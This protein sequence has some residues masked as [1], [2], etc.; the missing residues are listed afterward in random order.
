MDE[1]IIEINQNG[2]VPETGLS[3]KSVEVEIPEVDEKKELIPSLDILPEKAK[4]IYEE[5]NEKARTIISSINN[6]LGITDSSPKAL[7]SY[8]QVTKGESVP[9]DIDL[10]DS[11]IIQ[12]RHIDAD[13]QKIADGTLPES[14]KSTVLRQEKNPI[15]KISL[16]LNLNSPQNR[17]SHLE[18]AKTEYERKQSEIRKKLAETI[19]PSQKEHLN[20]QNELDKQTLHTI[21]QN[22]EIEDEVDVEN[23]LSF[24]RRLENSR[25]QRDRVQ[26]IRQ[27]LIEQFKHGEIEN[28]PTLFWVW[29]SL[30][31]QTRINSGEPENYTQV[32]ERLLNRIQ[33]RIG[34][35]FKE[36]V[37]N[38]DSQDTDHTSIYLNS[39]IIPLINELQDRLLA[40]PNTEN[41][42]KHLHFLVQG[43]ED[44]NS[45]IGQTDELFFHN[46]A[47]DE[48]FYS[49]MKNGIL[50]HREGIKKG[51]QIE[52]VTGSGAVNYTLNSDG[53]NYAGTHFSWDEIPEKMSDIRSTKDWTTE[54][55]QVLFEQNGAYHSGEWAVVFPSREIRSRYQYSSDYDGIHVFDPEY[56]D[57]VSV[58][59][60]K[61]KRFNPEGRGCHIE[62]GQHHFLIALTEK[63]LN[64]FLPYFQNNF[65]NL[66]GRDSVNDIDEWLERY[67]IRVND[68]RNQEE[69]S[70]IREAMFSRYDVEKND[71]VEIASGNVGTSTAHEFITKKFIHSV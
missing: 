13:F 12:S 39:E 27:H 48:V 26:G 10:I 64:Q 56:S 61:T 53:I 34:S 8:L 65:D 55:D 20:H 71:G 67:T 38:F 63:G 66:P 33:F 21:C 30:D 23:N 62:L 19:S 51:V 52:F 3:P 9:I 46:N 22:L 58:E 37:N 2:N 11:L 40:T 24:Q 69:V 45:K 47:R 44:H 59:E 60:R 31:L 1:N 7:E 54:I 41:M 15:K 36:L 14:Y 6:L 17:E 70:K 68:L 35:E 57:S 25:L 5:K 42:G 29:K 49:V 16:Y 50:S 43:M 18:T 4:L 28:D 32:S